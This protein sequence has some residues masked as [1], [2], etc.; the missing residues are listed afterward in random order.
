MGPLVS[1]GQRDTVRGF[2]EGPRTPATPP[3]DV[4]FRGTAPEG[5]GWWYPPTV[6]LPERPDGPGLARG[7][8]R[9]GRGGH[10]VR[11][12]GGRGR[13][14][15]TTRPTACPGRSGRATWAA[16]SG[17][18]VASRPGTSRSTATAR[19]ATRRPFGGFKASRPRPRAR[20]RTRSTRSPRSRT[21][22][23][24]PR[25]QE[26]SHGRQARGQGRGRHRR[27]L[28]HRVGDGAA[29]RRRRAR[30]GRRRR[31]QRRGRG[32]ARRRRS[33]APTCTPTS[34]A[35][36]TSTG[37]SRTAVETLRQARRRVQQRRHQPTRRRLDPRHG[38]RRV[39]SGPGGQPHLGLP[40]LQGGPA[41]HARAQVGL[42]HQ[43]RELRRGHGSGDLADLLL[44]LQ[45]RRAR[46]DPRA[47]RAV[48]ARR[49]P[50]QRALPAARSTPRCSRSCSPRTPSAPR[51]ASSTC[52]WA[53]SASPRRWRTPCCS[54]PPTSRAS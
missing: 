33:A 11:R 27:L 41:V 9:A 49:H 45:G 15:P 51:A 18:P 30:P 32:G 29:V 20:A 40:V 26:T 13:A 47:R 7:G 2:V 3:V 16:R 42:D 44:G 4:A 46:D 14:R 48:R 10:A 38:P 1:A 37:S 8:L 28:R 54:S 17:W 39:A 6:V 50:G 19:C 24:A 36:R 12:R 53:A 52:R 31:P 21:S 5:A 43:H 22:S 35:R 23:S 25:H 34:R